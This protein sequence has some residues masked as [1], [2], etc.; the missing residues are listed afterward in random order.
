MGAETPARAAVG[1]LITP[2]LGQR[3]WSHARAGDAVYQFHDRRP[4]RP[5]PPPEP[6]PN[7]VMAAAVS[8]SM[9]TSNSQCV[10]RFWT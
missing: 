6:G 5:A 1:N 9:M 3:R 8:T 7:G 10:P 2:A 4:P